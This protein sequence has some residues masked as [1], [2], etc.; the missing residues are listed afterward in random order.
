MTHKPITNPES[1][2]AGA[3]VALIANAA[4]YAM[5]MSQVGA[6]PQTV[7]KMIDGVLVQ[8]TDGDFVVKL[9]A[10]NATILGYFPRDAWVLCHIT[11]ERRDGGILD[12]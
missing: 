11:E 7:P 2:P 5:M 4:P 1:L 12:A 3:K 9:N 6:P 10:P 8:V